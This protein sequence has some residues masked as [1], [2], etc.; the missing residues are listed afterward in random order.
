MYYLDYFE[1]IYHKEDI[2]FHYFLIV[3][4]DDEIEKVYFYDCGR[5]NLMSISYE[6]LYKAMNVS[7]KGISNPNTICTIRINNPK[8]KKQIFIE[9]MKLKSEQFLILKLIS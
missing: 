3:G 1:K 7:C 9:T 6:N 4:Y 2:P 5:E 8:S